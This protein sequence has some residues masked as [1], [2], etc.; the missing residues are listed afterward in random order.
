VIVDHDLHIHTSLSECSCDPLATPH[1]IIA[2]AASL[3]LRTIGLADHMWDRRVPGASP[4]YRPQTYERLAQLRNHITD[5]TRG[6]RVLLGCE[7][8]YCGG[9]KVGISPEV[10]ERLD[11]V[12]IP[13][14]H[15]HMAGFV[16]PPSIQ[17][18]AG[19]ASLLLERFDEAVGLGLATGIAH[20]FLPLGFK[21]MTDEILSLVSDSRLLESF[22][23]AAEHGV[24]QEVSVSFFPGIT[25]GELPGFHDETFLR[26]LALA[27]QA[28]C[29]FH[30]AS[31]THTLE[32][33]GDSLSLEPYAE[34]AGIG[35]DDIL[36]LARASTGEGA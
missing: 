33:V 28:G 5:D 12:L 13:M 36:P 27:K 9:G 30:F 14:S 2:R 29:V 6:V 31:D 24:S 20:P 23:R 26:V 3:G 8:E 32:G 35:P 22:G 10:A 34:A 15:F 19:V 21:Q 11:F 18:P 16:R 25:G 17:A 1:N 7:T 4:W